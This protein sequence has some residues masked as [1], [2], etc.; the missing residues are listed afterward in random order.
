MPVPT[1]LTDLLRDVS[2]SFYLTLR[3][4]PGGVR[5][6][7]GLAYLLARATDTLADTALIPIERRLA[8]L[9][10]LQARIQDTSQ[11]TP[12]FDSFLE[13]EPAGPARSGLSDRAALKAVRTAAA[14]RR[15]LQRIPE[16][17]ALLDTF[18]SDDRQR[19]RQVLSVITSGQELDLTRF[20]DASADRIVAL[21]TDDELDD[22]IHRVAGCVG[23][24]WTRTCR[25][26]LFPHA[27]L[28][29]AFLLR[30]GVRFGKG[31]QLVNVLRDLPADLRKGRCYLP[32]R[33][34]ER[35]R[36]APDNLLAA[37][38][39]AQLET[40]L[41]Q[42]RGVAAA[43]LSAGW[44]YTNHLPW[45][46]V[47]ARLACAWPVLIGVQTLAKLEQTPDPSG[48]V[49][50]KISRRELRKML[51][52]SVLCYP[53]PRLWNGLFRRFGRGLTA[54]VAEAGSGVDRPET[55]GRGPEM[56]R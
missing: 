39:R 16:A 17:L 21:A 51:V 52:L 6:P 9:R 30:N 31:L 54:V 29:D 18:D 4:L 28:D 32:T 2:R 26:H 7:I 11:P 24:F 25:A 22:Y 42:Y 49:P 33:A 1:L 12:N 19:I 53:C 23:E 41:R 20:A 34:L 55:V 44:A 43:H 27:N 56:G 40:V 48:A 50:V 37:G 15:L 46:F 13:P 47:R 3:V 10:E 45:R 8:A 14:E 35:V 38:C 5:P 36:L